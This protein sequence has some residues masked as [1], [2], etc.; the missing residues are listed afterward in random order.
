MLLLP[1]LLGCVFALTSSSRRLGYGGGARLI[2]GFL[3]E[4]SISTLIA[5][6]LMLLQSGFVFSILAGR[7]GGWRSQDRH[8]GGLPLGE[9]LRLV[10]RESCAGGDLTV[11]VVWSAPAP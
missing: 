9:A 6:I 3:T 4:L 1:R 2:G 11:L 7:V 10:G 8:S 5:P